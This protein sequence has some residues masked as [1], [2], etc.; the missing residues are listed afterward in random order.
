MYK[1][2]QKSPLLFALAAIGIYVVGSGAADGLSD[3]LGAPKSITLCFHLLLSL[4][5]LWFLFRHGLWRSY[6]IC[7]PKASPAHLLF[8][9]PLAVM[10]SCNLWIAPS[11][12]YRG[13]TAVL[14]VGS[15]VCVG[16][17]EELIFRGLLFRAV[18][19]SSVRAAVL[20][21]SL[22]FGFGH[23]INLLNGNAES[24]IANLCQV[25]T[26]ICFGF[27]FV[28]MFYR[29][30]S[31]LPCILTHSVLNG[32]SVLCPPLSDSRQITV[33]AILSLLALG[34]L[35]LLCL[36]LPKPTTDRN[37]AA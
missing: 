9:L 21:S 2:Y 13:L 22:T 10:A 26:A 35:T 11:L 29:G 33:S 20:L 5:L 23:L 18:A 8:Y 6:G 14:Y 37:E 15:M 28:L 16:F 12:Q 36:L 1:L 27:L 19:Q 24:L 4:A 3:L 25:V 17:L 31:L 34:Y 7:K 30:G 32:L